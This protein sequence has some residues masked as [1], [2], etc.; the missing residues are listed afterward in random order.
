MSYRSQLEAA[1]RA[2]ARYTLVV[3]RRTAPSGRHLGGRSGSSFELLEHREYQPGDDLRHLD[4]SAYA[5]SDRLMVKLFHEEVQPHVDLLLDASRSMALQG[6]AKAGAAAGL[7]AFLT[8][9]AA[10]AGLTCGVWLAADGCRRLAGAGRFEGDSAGPPPAGLPLV[11]LLEN[12][13]LEHRGSLGQSLDRLPPR[14]RPRGIRLLLSDLLWDEQ[15]RAVLARVARGAAAV[16]V[17]QLLASADVDPGR[18][19]GGRPV[20]L[21]DSE[22]GEVRDLLL[23]AAALEA[24]RRALGTH[25]EG[26][27][28]AC[29]EAGAVMVTLVAERLVDGWRPEA[30]EGLV[31]YGMVEVR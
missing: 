5:R 31:R 3:P 8:R 16:W 20:R 25:R 21:E 29:R 14:W 18:S 15:P 23:D 13:E 17:V 24:Y 12:L 2:A 30:L 9:A 10:R 26:W 22:T 4:W 28:R 11:R 1:E 6:S 7:V 19:P 27:H